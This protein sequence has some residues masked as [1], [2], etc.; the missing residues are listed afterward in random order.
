MLKLLGAVI[1]VAAG[2]A[3]GMLV[4]REYARRPEE[5][6]SLLSSIQMLET[7]IIYAATPLAEALVRVAAVSDS[8]VSGLFQKAARELRDMTGCTAG[9]AWE[10][11]LG[12]FYTVNSLTRREM[13][14]LSNL[15]RALGISDRE[16]QAKHLKLA[17]EQL[18]REIARAEEE[19]A[20]NTRMW[21]YLG[22]CGSMAAAIILY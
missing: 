5:L 12:W 18:K 10:R 15:G 21:N 4:A 17:C 3:A 8:H 9:E 7:E 1:L 22:F 14:I 13:S 11:S 2:G 6:K 16:D 20:K 19:A